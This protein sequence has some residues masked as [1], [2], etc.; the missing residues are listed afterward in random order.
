V[1][2]TLINKAQCYPSRRV[3]MHLDSSTSF[4]LSFK[5]GVSP[6]APPWSEIP[7]WPVHLPA[8]SSPSKNLRPGFNQPLLQYYSP[9]PY[10]SQA[11]RT[12]SPSR[13]CQESEYGVEGYSRICGAWVGAYDY[14]DEG[15]S[16][17]NRVGRELGVC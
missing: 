3:H 16:Y 12:S 1:R 13:L 11:Y 6:S 8:S 4:G 10:P 5:R 15:S 9:P 17:E 2:E 14:V 7:S